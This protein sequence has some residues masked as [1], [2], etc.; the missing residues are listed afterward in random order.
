MMVSVPSLHD[1]AS[2]HKIDCFLASEK[3]VDVDN[4]LLSSTRV[5]VAYFFFIAKAQENTRTCVL[6][7]DFF[8]RRQTTYNF[9][10]FPIVI[11]KPVVGTAEKLAEPDYDV[12]KMAAILSVNDYLLCIKLFL[13]LG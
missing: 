6:S 10:C 13:V 8:R 3:V 4:S 7:W 1:N 12:I 5:P 2:S 9:D 11:A